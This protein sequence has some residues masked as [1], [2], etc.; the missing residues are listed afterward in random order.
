MTKD[1]KQAVL[2]YLE[3]TLTT[4]VQGLEANKIIAGQHQVGEVY[5]A[6]YEVLQE[7]ERTLTDYEDLDQKAIS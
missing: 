1:E 6:A 3:F 4:M 7:M 5:D 2:N